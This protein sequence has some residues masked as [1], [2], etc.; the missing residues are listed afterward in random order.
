MT[1]L[2]IYKCTEKDLNDYLGYIKDN[3]SVSLND[4]IK[5]KYFAEDNDK[6]IITSLENIEINADL[7]NANFQGTILTD[8]VF[9]NC[10]LTNTILCD[11]D[12]T[13]VKFNDCTFIGTDFRGANLHYTD[14]NYKDYDYD[15]YKIPN[16]KDKIRDIKLS[17]SDL[18]RLNQY[19]DKDLEKEHIKEIVIDEA[20]KTKKYILAGED[21]KTLWEIKSKELKTKQEELETL[22][23]NLDNPGIATNLLNAFWNSAETIARNR[24]NELE[25]INKLQ[26]EVN[27]LETEVYALDNLRMFCGKG[28]D[29]IFEQLKDEEIQIKLDPSYIIGSTAKERDIPKEYIKL[30]SAEFDLYLA[31]AAK[32]SNTKLSLTEFVRKQK[33]L[34]EDL[35]IVP[36][37][38]AI[39]LSGKTLT[40]LNLK[41][42]LFASANLENIKISNCNLDFTNFEGANLQ[43]AVFQNVT[44]RNAGFL[45]ADL[46]KSKIENS[47]MSRAYMPKVD[48]SEVEV[49]NSKFN[50]VMMVNADA[51]KLIIKDSEWKNSNLTGISLAYADMQRVQMQGVVL[52]N[53]LLDQA[54]IVSTDLENVFMNKTHALEAKFKEQCNMQGITARNA[55][56]SDA[57]FENILSLKEADLREAIM[58]RVKLKNAD[59]TKAQLDKAN[60]E[61][62]DLTNATLTNATAQFAKLSNATLEKAEAEGLNISDAIAKNINAKEAN[63]KNAIMKRADLTKANFT[64]AVLE[65][66]DMQAAEAAEAIFKEANLK[67][68]NLKAANLAGI[69]KEGADFD[70]AKINDATKMYDTKGEAKGNLDHQDKDGKKTSVNVNEH[71]KLQ[72]KIHAREKSGWFLKTGVG[73]ICT[74]LAKS[75]ISGISRVTNFL[76]SKKFLVGFAVVSGLAVTAAPFVAMPVLLVTGTALTTKAVILGAGILAGVLVAT[77]TYKLTQKPLHNLQKSFENLTS[78]IDKY[79]SPPPKNIDELVIEK[80]QAR[81]KAE[82]EKSKEREENLN[83]VNNNIDKAKE[84]DLLKQAQNNLN[85]ATPK[86]E[87]KEKQDKTVEKQQA[88]SNTFALKFKPNTKGKGFATKIKD[89]KKSHSIKEVYN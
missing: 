82:T 29:G 36:D 55:Y 46:K 40:N 77:G 24:Q 57:E 2:N 9:N 1:N 50:A 34:S 49:T 74:K 60:L 58:Q 32:Q 8:A 11:S 42:T 62:A 48:L 25:K 18:E 68:A 83:N 13:N 28:L 26:H 81:Q 79:I 33:N 12:L 78:S 41:N 53:A 20:T 30:T 65:N 39:N 64:K 61:Y 70:K 89:E 84:Q 47:D 67:Q 44:A 52:N 14:F 56:F 5:N 23:Q 73:Q 71:A 21:E 59:L 22:K 88:T 72:D 10:D 43:N 17:F 3:P 80:Q 16:L 76:A 63:F 37:L 51:E 35:N 86:V 7:A 54:N 66:A 19:I 6:I 27:K 38:S 69:N 15:N 75:T 31:E 85:Q 45:F 4:F 87:I